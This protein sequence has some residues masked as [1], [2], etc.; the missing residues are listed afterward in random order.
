[1]SDQWRPI[2]HG[3]APA[4]L[5]GIIPLAIKWQLRSDSV[6]APQQDVGY[7]PTKQSA[8]QIL[9]DIS[10]GGTNLLICIRINNE[11]DKDA[12]HSLKATPYNP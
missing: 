10:D 6:S 3:K 7:C 5:G 2:L 9:N 12:P 4:T 8:I 1:M 11:D